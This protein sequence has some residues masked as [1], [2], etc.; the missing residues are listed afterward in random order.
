[1]E[2]G[3]SLQLGNTAG[4]GW[5]LAG[6]LL[7]VGWRSTVVELE[8]ETGDFPADLRLHMTRGTSLPDRL[9]RVAKIARLARR[10]DIVHFH[11]GIRPFA[12]YVRRICRAPFVV[13]FHGS[14]L[15]ERLSDGYRDLAAAEFIATPDL[16]RWAPRATWI[17]NPIIIPVLAPRSSS[18][19]LVVGHFPSDPVKKG[20]RQIVEAVRKVQ[21][22]SEFDFRL[23]SG[24]SHE[25]ALRQMIECD[26]VIDQLSP[27]GVYGMVSVEAM[28]FGRVVLSSIDGSYYDR[29]PIVP[30]TGETLETML[31]EI[32]SRADR[33]EH[34]GNEGRLYVER[35]HD[36]VRVARRVLEE[37][38]RVR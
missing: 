18:G 5:N 30:I 7:Q 11:F 26:V 4:I 24:V 15:R 25:A 17:P 37:Y 19:R 38:E 12:R 2:H 31:S 9:V 29:C 1:M 28:S 20:T 14:D 21:S 33:R 10:S 13:H 22:Q 36:P 35:V 27:F 34:L 3:F 32:L 23:V 16:K 8:P 6:G